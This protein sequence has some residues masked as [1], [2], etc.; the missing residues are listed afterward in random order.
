[1]SAVDQFI[2]AIESA[3]MAPPTT[4]HDDGKLHRFSPTGKRGDDAGWYV[5]HLDGVP[6]GSFGDWRSGES[7]T[8]CAKP[9]RNL[10]PAERQ[11]VRERIRAAQRLRD[12]ETMRRN[13]EAASAAR[14]IWEA[15][16]L[17]VVHPY[18]TAKG[19]KPHGLRV[20]R[21]G[22]LLVPMRDAGGHL[23]SL[24]TIGA[25]GSKRFMAGGQVKG[26]YH[27]IG[28]IKDR[29]VVCEGYATGATIHEDTG[30]AVACAFS[31]S[32]LLPVTQSLRKKYPALAIVIAADD[33]AHL[34][35]NTGLQSAKIAALSIRAP[36][37]VARHLDRDPTQP[38][39]FN[40]LHALYGP[41]AVR[42]CFAELEVPT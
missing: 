32:N 42:A 4:L 21:Y 14:A 1:M 17:A 23:L 41:D 7:Q 25:D 30:D 13:D 37:V 34:A 31:A 22:N 24:Q 26:C 40:D 12:A 9:D 19:V 35:V 36:V 15:A 27:S 3:G 20:G 10:S 38:C 11:V 6:A 2:T 29:L 8:W 28:A 39:D 33:D 16:A 5:L 18:L